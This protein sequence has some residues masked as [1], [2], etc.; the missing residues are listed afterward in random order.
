M[1]QRS[2]EEGEG[3]V[4]S[5]AQLDQGRRLAKAGPAIKVDQGGKAP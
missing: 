5:D 2:M 3:E 1:D 4:D